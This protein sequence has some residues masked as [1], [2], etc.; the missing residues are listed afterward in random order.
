MRTTVTPEPKT[1]SRSW[2]QTTRAGAASPITWDTSGARA[3]GLRGTSTAPDRSTARRACTDSSVARALHRTRSPGPTPWPERTEA[4]RAVCPSSAAPS[5]VRVPSHPSTSTGSPGRLTHCPAHTA[6]RVGPG[7]TGG[8]SG[9][10][11]GGTSTL[12]ARDATP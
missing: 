9:H 12:T 7:A 1:S 8:S 10:R 11:P 2:S 5:S 6:G 4:S 3:D